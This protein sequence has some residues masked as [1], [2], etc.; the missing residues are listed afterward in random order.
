MSTEQ[1]HSDALNVYLHKQLKN[2]VKV[3][4]LLRFQ[5]VQQALNK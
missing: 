3:L 4:Q 2:A 5:I 1:T